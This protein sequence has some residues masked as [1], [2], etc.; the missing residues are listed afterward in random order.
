M[1]EPEFAS[2]L[3]AMQREGNKL[4]ALIRQAWETGDLQSLTKHSA[5][6]A[7][8]A[9]ISIIGH[10]T[11]NDLLRYLD[12]TEMANGFANRFLWAMGRRS[13]VLPEGGRIHEVNFHPILNRL[14]QVRRFLGLE[15]LDLGDYRLC[16]AEE[17][18]KEWYRV[19]PRLSE[20]APGML[21]AITGRA[22]A[23]V[24]RLATLYALLDL[25]LEIRLE[26]LRAA[27]AVWKYCEDSAR[28]IFGSSLGDPNADALLRAI[29]DSGVGMNRT[30]I[31]EFFGHKKHV[32]EIDRALTTLSEMG[33]L[34][35]ERRD[36][37]GRP[38][39]RWVPV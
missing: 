25:T 29:R 16:W 35:M 34:R 27:L 11:K 24:T 14:A 19:Y 22:E 37:G 9:H 17:A 21:G 26:H 12:S 2:V 18:L 20:G 33:L 13:R 31:N 3:N 32:S 4:S 1:I 30:Q 23:Q 36:T 7:T 10:T 5:A 39:E 15:D 8:G 38:Q 28:F 6:V